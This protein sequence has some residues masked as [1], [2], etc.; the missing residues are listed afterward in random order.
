MII[1]DNCIEKAIQKKS[2]SINGPNN[3]E[4]KSKTGRAIILWGAI[5]KSP[6]LLI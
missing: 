3:Y 5:E 4:T 1:S 6:I 2:V